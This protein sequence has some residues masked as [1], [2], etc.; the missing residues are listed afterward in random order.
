MFIIGLCLL[1]ILF[2]RDTY[3]PFLGDSVLPHSLF[4]PLNNSLSSYEKTD[5]KKLSLNIDA[6]NGTV[7]Y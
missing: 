6:P 4:K 5:F 2:E 7:H 1:N 3:L